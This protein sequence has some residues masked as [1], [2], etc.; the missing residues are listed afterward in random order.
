MRNR[1]KSIARTSARQTRNR[2]D[3]G[4]PMDLAWAKRRTRRKLDLIL[5]GD[6][7]HVAYVGKR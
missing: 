7:F 6:L 4:V 1:P 2:L 5:S 3:C